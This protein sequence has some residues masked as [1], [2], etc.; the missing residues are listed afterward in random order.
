MLNTFTAATVANAHFFPFFIRW[1]IYSC[2]P[3]SVSSD[4]RPIYSCPMSNAFPS[5]ALTHPQLIPL[6]NL[7]RYWTHLQLLYS[8]PMST[9]SPSSVAYAFTAA[10]LAK[11]LQ[12]LDT[13]L[14]QLLNLHCF[15]TSDAGTICSCLTCQIFTHS[16]LQ[17]LT[18]TQLLTFP[19]LHCYFVFSCETHL[20]PA[21]SSLHPILQCLDPFT[22][23]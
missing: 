18:H 3:C 22:A 21:E 11:S 13:Q 7:F 12:I 2:F 1:L 5:S 9:A 23:C 6:P 19:N 20:Q 16:F 8:C 4:A 15:P 14:L 10:S 17:L